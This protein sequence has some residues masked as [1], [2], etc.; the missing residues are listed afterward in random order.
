VATACVAVTTVAGVTV[1]PIRPA[2]AAEPHYSA[3][4]AFRAY[5]D[6]ATPDETR[7]WPSGEPLPVGTT[8]DDDGTVH[9]NRTYIAY[10]IAG[11]NGARLASARLSASE[12]SVADCSVVRALSVRPIVP[13]DGHTW[14]SPPATAGAAVPLNATGT[15]CASTV[16]ADLT[17][18]LDR[19]LERDQDKLWLELRVPQRRETDPRYARR[20]YDQ[21][22]FEVT[23]TNRPPLK[24]TELSVWNGDIPCSDDFT[25]NQDFSVFANMA[26]PDRHPGDLL[27]PEFVFWNTATPGIRTPMSTGI[28]SGA[29]LN[30]VG[31]VPVR[32]LPDG[33][34]GWHARVFDT[35]AYSPWSDSC[36]FT[37]DRTAPGSAPT[38]SSPEYPED[39]PTP[40]GLVRRPGTF[41]FTANG[42]PDVVAF[43]F[44]PDRWSTE[45]VSADEPGGAATARWAPDEAGVQTLS[46]WSID[47]AGNRSPERTYRI[48]VRGFEG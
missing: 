13:F 21:I 33:R 43:E 2:A 44:G 12:Y 15:G 23:L 17:T 34:Y 1:L 8:V 42:V 48:N 20:F 7:Y 39:S 22:R 28:E 26:D 38:V 27:T 46:V 24:P 36:Y 10:E 45:R 16:T 41:L 31:D 18:A 3:T 40:T 19:A 14:A 30:G 32:T 25:V 35:R 47:R 11:M 37:V 4:E 9:T 29:E 6:A 5:T